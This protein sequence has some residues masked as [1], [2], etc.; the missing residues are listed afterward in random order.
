M[1]SQ[2]EN[3]LLTQVGPGS[4]MGELFRRFWTPVMLASELPAADGAPVRVNVLGEKL[5][6][7]RNTSGQVGLLD[8]YCPHRR[9]N[10]FWGRNEADG[11]R[12]VYHGWKFDAAGQCVDMPNC[13]EGVTLKERVRTR[14]YPT[15]ER[16]GLVFAYFG[17]AE[18]QPAFPDIELFGSTPERR[19]ATK[20]VARGNWLQLQE[21]DI[22]SSHVAFL[23][24]RIDNQPLEGSRSTPN[25]F[26]DKSPRWFIAETDYGL[27]LS[28]Q[29]EAGPERFQWRVNQYLMPYVTLIA[30]VPG[31]PVLAQIRVP[32]DDETSMLI[33]YFAHPERALSEAERA[34]YDGGVTVPE[35]IPGTFETVENASNDYRIDRDLQRTATFTGIRS[36]VAQ[37][38][39]VAQDQG[40]GPRLD[41]SQEYLVSSD[42]AI[43]ALR[44]RLL[45]AVKALQNGVEPPEARNGRAYGV[46]PGDFMLPRDIAVAEGAKDILVATQ[47]R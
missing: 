31:Q 25:T 41:R 3:E 37:D 27:M 24:S 26:L 11:L 1:L 16:G 40:G 45:T 10:L 39:A 47:A 23:H 21:G 2:A 42:R 35:L 14:A 30:S 32:I 7:F 44:K 19:H 12:C 20:I 4:P 28:A 46:R 5:V 15:L 8:A 6:A 22:D 29:R 33:R 9:A 13:P 38:L 17:P 18:R 34:M 43:I 36:I